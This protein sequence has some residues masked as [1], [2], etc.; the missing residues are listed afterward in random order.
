[1]VGIKTEVVVECTSKWERQVCFR[2]ESACEE[3]KE[4]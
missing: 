2:V 4:I 3:S 1:M